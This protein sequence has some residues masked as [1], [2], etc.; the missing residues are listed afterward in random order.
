MRL[1]IRKTM[2]AVAMVLSF[3]FSSAL[4][5]RAQTAASNWLPPTPRDAKT[6][7][8]PKP[9]P[10]H[11]TFRGDANLW[12]AQ[13]I[14]KLE[15]G[16]FD[17]IEDKEITGYVSAVGRHLTKYSVNPQKELQ[18][19]V[20]TDWS[21]NAMTAGGGKIYISC[22]MLEQLESEDELAA[23]LSHEIAHDAFHHAARMVTRQMFWLTGTRQIRTAAEAEAALKELNEQLDDNQLAAATDRL[24]GFARIDELEADRAAFYNTYKAGYNPHA[25]ASSLRRL[26]QTEA[27]NCE[28]RTWHFKLFLALFGSHPPTSQRILALKWEA[29]F[30]KMPEKNV[31]Y[32]SAAFDAMKQRIKALAK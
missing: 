24:L 19:I 18:L 25:L 4:S 16:V 10:G 27:E 29:N 11:D 30:V 14:E 7:L 22:G 12:L 31:R 28:E 8:A 1:K 15:G 17:P 3:W 21:A 9:V 6:P 20:T 13:A 5:Q 26:E 32:S 2:T 23:I